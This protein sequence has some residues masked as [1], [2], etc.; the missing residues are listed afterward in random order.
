M[1]CRTCSRP[2]HLGQAVDGGRK[3]SA[4]G[5]LTCWSC[6]T[7]GYVCGEHGGNGR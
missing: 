3:R 7:T 4:F 1:K 2:A 5:A 6:S